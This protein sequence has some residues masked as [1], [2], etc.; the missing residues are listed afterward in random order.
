MPPVI[1]KLL[2]IN[3]AVFIIQMIF[4]NLRFGDYPGWYI[5]NRYFALNPIVGM[6]QA[7]QPFNFQIWQIFTYQFMHGGF[8]HLFF[9]FAGQTF[10]NLTC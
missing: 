7:G 3:V 1:K 2:I 6:D 9:N 8:T 5:L 4:D 10:T